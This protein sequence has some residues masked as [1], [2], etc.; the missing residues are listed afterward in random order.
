MFIDATLRTTA[1]TICSLCVLQVGELHPHVATSM[2]NLG[3]VYK[4]LGAFE[5]AIESHERS[6]AIRIKVLGDGHPHVA[7]SLNN[8]G[9]V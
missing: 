6:L 1:F 2:C 9:M 3:A 4:E 5:K 8:L 7:S